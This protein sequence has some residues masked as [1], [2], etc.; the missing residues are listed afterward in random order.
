MARRSRARETALQ[1]LYRQDLNPAGNLE[2]A[3]EFIEERLEDQALRDFCWNLF[4]GAL[5]WRNVIDTRIE[6]VAANWSLRRMAPTDRNVLRLGAYELL[7]TDTP[8]R[9]VIDESL[10]LAKKFGN[11][12]SS[13]FVNGILDQL[14]PTL[15]DESPDAPTQAM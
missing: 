5:E 14:M 13:Q 11:A 2:S 9:V 6:E 7:Y 15:T 3:G 1:L 8:N 4:T 12:Q 10:E